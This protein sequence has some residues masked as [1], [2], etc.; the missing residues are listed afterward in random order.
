MVISFSL[1]AAAVVAVVLISILTVDKLGAINLPQPMPPY[2]RAPKAVEIVAVHRGTPEPGIRPQIPVRE[3]VAPSRIPAKV[4]MVDDGPQMLAAAPLP[5]GFGSAAGDVASGLAIGSGLPA[6]GVTPP[7]PPPPPPAAVKQASQ[8]TVRLGGNVMEA[9]LV[10]RVMPVYPPLARQARISGKVSLQGVISR[11]GRVIN[12]EVRSGHPLLIASAV[13]AVRQWL[14]QPT[15]LNGEPVEVI[16]P[17]E[18]NFVLG[19]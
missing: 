13:D 7:P 10:R 3:F 4:A 1:Q 16:A 19:Q 9:K 12:L 5:M 8:K 17:I 15:L 2:P 6:P 18:V 14:Y 11:D